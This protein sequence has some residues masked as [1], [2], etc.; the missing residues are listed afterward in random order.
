MDDILKNSYYSNLGTLQNKEAK[1]MTQHKTAITTLMLCSLL[2]ITYLA[3]A[4]AAT[5]GTLTATATT[6]SNIITLTGS[7]FGATENVTLSILN[8]TDNSNVY[9][10]T[11]TVTTD[12]AGAFAANV[13]LPPG[14]YGTYNITAQTSTV[15]A[16]TEYTISGAANLTVTPDDSNIIAVSGSGF[17]ANQTVTLQLNDTTTTTA[18]TFPEN[19]TTNSQGN[20][21]STII[22]PTSLSG[23]YTIVASTSTA[24]ANATISVPDFTGPTG[25]TGATGSTGVAGVAGADGQ[26]AD[27]TAVYLALVASV[28][29][30]AVALFT[31]VK[32]H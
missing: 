7:G 31:F 22:I 8:E 25:A 26:P 2:A 3:V 23:S 6:T 32:K 28:I 29:A 9:N 10:F 30:I 27:N 4:S 18:Y 11:E 21:T 15:N 14:I 19:I 24:T 17:N 16:Y 5:T 12:S 20:F 1:P 13:T